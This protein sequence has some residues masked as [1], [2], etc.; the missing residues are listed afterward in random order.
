MREYY[1]EGVAFYF[2]FLESLTWALLFPSIV[3]IIQ[4]FSPSDFNTRLFFCILYILWAFALME[5]WKRRSNGLCFQW[6]TRNKFG[7]AHAE[8][9]ANYRGELV[10]DPITGTLLPFYPRWKTLLKLYGVSLPIVLVCTAAA[11]Y[12]MLES[13]W[14]ESMLIEFTS[15]WTNSGLI[16]QY[17]ALA[18]VSV[19][20]VIYAALVWVA[21]MLYRRLA[22]KLTEWENHRTESQFERNRVTKLLLFEF[23]NN[24]MSLFYIAFY[25]KDISMLKWVYN[26]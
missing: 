9:R 5:W 15:D 19:P 6:G 20:T 17:L 21:N 22:T 24:F 16:W 4:L 13:I 25:L 26:N 1:G 2:G 10:E 18:V 8:P 7:G 11:F 3:G 23:V 12:L 14:K